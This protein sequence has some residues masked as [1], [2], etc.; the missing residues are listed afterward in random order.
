MLITIPAAYPSEVLEIVIADDQGL[1]PLLVTY[2]NSRFQAY[3]EAESRA[4]RGTLMLRS[5]VYWIEEHLIGIFTE[6][7]KQ[8]NT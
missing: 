7:L 8:V 2:G 6:A 3:L 4:F 1:N 5:V